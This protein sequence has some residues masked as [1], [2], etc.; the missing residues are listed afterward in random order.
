MTM[1]LM[2][3]ALSGD[4]RAELPELMKPGRIPGMSAAGITNG[5][6]AWTEAWGVANADSEEK[7]TEGTVFQAASLSKPVFAYLC[8]KLV[9]EGLLDLDKPLAEILPNPR[10]Q[11]DARYRTINAR[12]VLAHRT[13]LPNWGGDHLELGFDP[14]ARF[15]YSGEG[16]VYLGRVVEEVTGEEIGQAIEKRVLAPLGM[17]SSAFVWRADYEARVAYPHNST[18]RVQTPRRKPESANT[19]SSLHTTAADYARFVVAVMKGE[20]LSE[21]SRREMLRNQGSVD[22]VFGRSNED[23]A[24]VAGWSLGWGH[25]DLQGGPYHWHWG[26]NG[27][28]KAFVIWSSSTSDGL[29]YFTNGAEGLSIMETVAARFAPVTAGKLVF[30]DYTPYDAPGRSARLDG[31]GL[32]ADKRFTEAIE[33]LRKAVE[34]GGEDATLEV[35]IGWAEQMVAVH[36]KPL[37]LPAEGLASLAGSYGP[38]KLRLRDG[39]LFYQRD[40]RPEYRLIPVAERTFALDGYFPFRL[41]VVMD[42]DGKPEKLVGHYPDGNTDETPRDETPRG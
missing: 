15:G 26:D 13:G 36:K 27:D 4:L 11:R 9:D 19:A 17:T 20:G 39:S 2:C 29:V 34:A 18:G 40:G 23:L 37:L 33:H 22:Q 42:A 32:L 14:G 21:A 10:M 6:V 12:M 5:S 1:W 24:D 3:L 16:Y 31:L 41:E 35:M 7:V 30:L 8:M 28:F 25:L 38:R